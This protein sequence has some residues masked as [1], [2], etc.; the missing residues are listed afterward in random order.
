M[1]TDT[2]DEKKE[3]MK[4]KAKLKSSRQYDRVYIEIDMT[5]ETRNFQNV[6]RTVLKELGK[7][8]NYT[9]AGSRLISKHT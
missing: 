3:I 5:T 2:F 7:E 6:V 8:K 1:E 9:I 4:N